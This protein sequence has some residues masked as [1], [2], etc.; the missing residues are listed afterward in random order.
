MK[1]ITEYGKAVKRRLIDLG[2]TQEWLIAEVS[3]ESGLFLDGGY[4]HK[5]MTGQRAAP[6]IVAAINRILSIETTEKDL[7]S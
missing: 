4:L 1:N 2:Q 7:R 5:I 6:K 3:R